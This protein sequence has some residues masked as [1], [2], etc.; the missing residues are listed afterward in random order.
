MS[1]ELPITLLVDGACGVCRREADFLLR[2]DRGRG[3]IIVK[4]LVD[5]GTDPECFGCSLEQAM[6]EIHG[7]LPDGRVV[8]GMEVFRRA[9]AAVGLGWLL[10]PTA[11]PGLRA[12]FDRL[13]SLV[14]RHR[15]RL[16]GGG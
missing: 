9:Y 16:F 11:W 5:P 6:R 10:A 14:A 4:D 13:Y 3:R 12:L 2:L 15:M 8:T 7:V 1:D